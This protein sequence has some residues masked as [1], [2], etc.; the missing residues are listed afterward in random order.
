MPAESHL[1]TP[2]TAGINTRESLL[3]GALPFPARGMARPFPDRPF[4][5]V[6]RKKTIFI[7]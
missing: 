7:L 3:S 2:E 4:T 6:K 5:P 1:K